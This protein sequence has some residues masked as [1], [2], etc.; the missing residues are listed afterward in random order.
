M[1]SS[2]ASRLCDG[3][4]DSS[5]IFIL[6]EPLRFKMTIHVI[7]IMMRKMITA[8]VTPIPAFA[9]SLNPP[10]LLLSSVLFSTENE[11]LA[12]DE[13]RVCVGNEVTAFGLIWP[14]VGFEVKNA[15]CCKFQPTIGMAW[16]VRSDSKVV[17]IK[18][19]PVSLL[20][21]DQPYVRV[22]PEETCDTQ[23]PSTPVEKAAEFDRK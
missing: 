5:L 3:S 22:A 8:A 12:V 6:A 20:D 19:S 21:V 16:T 9:P 17:S 11:P 14:V 23:V 10:L 1:R 15:V 13:E 4:V 18:K 2:S 7:R